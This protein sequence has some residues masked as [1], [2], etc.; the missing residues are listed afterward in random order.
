[1]QTQIAYYYRNSVTDAPDSA[2]RHNEI[3]RLLSQLRADGRIAECVIQETEGGFPSRDHEEK[4]LNRLREFALRHKVRLSQ[5]FGSRRHGFCYLPQ[6][7]V[8]VSEGDQLREVFPC[9]FGDGGQMEP[10][11]YLKRLASGKPWT[12]RAGRGMEGKRH[13]QI[14]ARIINNPNSLEPGL[15]LRGQN[16]QVSRDVGELGFVDLVF[17]DSGGHSLLVEVKVASNEL[18]KAIGQILR[19]RNLFARQNQ[20]DETSIRMGIACPSIPSYCRSICA[21]ARISCFEIR[22]SLGPLSLEPAGK[23]S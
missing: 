17:E 12:V 9:E 13:K 7:F 14:I 20:L 5:Q 23:A 2:G 16:V 3:C 6:Q 19:H 4:L 22:E 8:L 10:L 1:M 18:D 21:A 11:E 15:I